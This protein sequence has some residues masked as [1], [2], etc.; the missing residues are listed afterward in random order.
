MEIRL[1]VI[2]QVKMTA[3]IRRE[4]IISGEGTAIRAE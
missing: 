1:V 2:Q 3:V 4:T